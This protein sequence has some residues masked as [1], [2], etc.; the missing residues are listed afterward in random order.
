MKN[1]AVKFEEFLER[2]SEFA[3]RNLSIQPVAPVTLDLVEYDNHIIFGNTA[4]AIKFNDTHA[5]NMLYVIVRTDEETVTDVIVNLLYSRVY[6]STD[7]DALNEF[8]ELEGDVY[9]TE[10]ED[11]VKLIIELFGSEFLLTV[12]KRVIRMDLGV[13]NKIHPDSVIVQWYYSL[14]FTGKLDHEYGRLNKD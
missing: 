14:L 8:E 2:L 7:V 9:L 12:L 3:I 4:K 10:S 5:N 13:G 1:V 6:H 11:I